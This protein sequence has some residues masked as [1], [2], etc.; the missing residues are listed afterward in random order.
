VK[1]TFGQNFNCSSRRRHRRH[2]LGMCGKTTSFLLQAL[3]EFGRTRRLFCV[4]TLSRNPKRFSRTHSIRPNCCP[5]FLVF[6]IFATVRSMAMGGGEG[7]I[8]W[9][10]SHNSNKM[11]RSQYPSFN[12]SKI[13]SP[14]R[15]KNAFKLCPT[16]EPHVTT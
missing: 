3:L 11:S 16:Y 7:V 6:K 1:E 8:I 9:N 14:F 12:K 15:N 4:T 2:R 13:F 5:L 10:K